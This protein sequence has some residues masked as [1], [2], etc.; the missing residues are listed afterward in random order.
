MK[1]GQMPSL[2]WLIVLHHPNMINQKSLS[3]TS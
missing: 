1:M 2:L 3:T